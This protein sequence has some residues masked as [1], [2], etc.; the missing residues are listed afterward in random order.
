MEMIGSYEVLSDKSAIG[1][2][3]DDT[4][5]T[6]TSKGEIKVFA[7][8]AEESGKLTIDSARALIMVLENYAPDLSKVVPNHQY[9]RPI[10]G[11]NTSGFPGVNLVRSS[12]KW[13]ARVSWERKQTS[14]GTAE[15][16]PAA[17]KLIVDFY[18]EK[19]GYVPSRKAELYALLVGTS[20]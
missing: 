14:L 2:R 17:A 10:N 11:R 8:R 19:L 18:K 1:I 9:N 6:V 5:V 3:I 15:S 12:G 20:E 7:P 13:H 4:Y 16:V